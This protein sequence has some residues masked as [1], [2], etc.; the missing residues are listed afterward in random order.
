MSLDIDILC[1]Q[2]ITAV[3]NGSSLPFCQIST[4]D[5][6]NLIS[7]DNSSSPYHQ[8]PDTDVSLPSSRTTSKPVPKLRQRQLW[9]PGYNAGYQV[10]LFTC[11]AGTVFSEQMRTCA[12][13]SSVPECSDD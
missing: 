3:P 2:V 11:G 9:K 6:D 12:F 13:P 10:Y 5:E 4:F 8:K 7:E 1:L